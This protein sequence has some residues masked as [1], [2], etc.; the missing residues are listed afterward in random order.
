MKLSRMTGEVLSQLESKCGE[1]G[2]HRTHGAD[3]QPRDS[4]ARS[5]AKKCSVV[6]S[7]TPKELSRTLS[8]GVFSLNE[9]QWENPSSLEDSRKTSGTLWGF[10]SK[11]FGDVVRLQVISLSL[12]SRFLNFHQ[13][14]KK[15][16][17][18]KER[19]HRHRNEG[20]KQHKEREKNKTKA[21]CCQ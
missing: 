1:F 7:G 19:K 6:T 11:I 9:T 3:A 5:R 18:W 20:K 15:T 8:T 2:S 17:T 10:A 4:S 21:N 14:I 12:A 13:I 16:Q